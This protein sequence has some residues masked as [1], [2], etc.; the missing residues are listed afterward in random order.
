MANRL[1]VNTTVVLATGSWSL[2]LRCLFPIRCRLQ[3]LRPTEGR[4]MSVAALRS[5]EGVYSIHQQ[6]HL[7]RPRSLNGCACAEVTCC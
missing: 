4:S 2:P 3:L 1:A 5:E 7:Y 6:S